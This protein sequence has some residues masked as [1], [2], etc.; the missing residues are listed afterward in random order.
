M[1]NISYRLG[2]KEPMKEIE[3]ALAGND[4]AV[5]TFEHFSDPLEGQRR[6]YRRKPRS[7]TAA[8]CTSISTTNASSTIRRPTP[9]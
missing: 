2:N 3:T 8:N 5:D 4:D 7:R 1:G 6:R 9:C